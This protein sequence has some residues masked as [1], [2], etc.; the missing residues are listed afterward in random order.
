[1]I[2]FEMRWRFRNSE[3]KIKKAKYI[4]LTGYS[5]RKLYTFS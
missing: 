4:N 2:K 3:K 5:T 1:M